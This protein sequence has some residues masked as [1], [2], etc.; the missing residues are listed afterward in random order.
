MPDKGSY[1]RKYYLHRR[2][3]AAGFCL[4]LEETVKT[5]EVT[6]NLVRK[7]KTNKYVAELRDRYSYG[8]QLINPMITEV[9]PK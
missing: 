3:K 5:I 9:K 7:A 8:V 6:D 1:D 2:V 4:K